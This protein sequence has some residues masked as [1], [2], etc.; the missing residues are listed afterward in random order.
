MI[1]ISD[2]IS[3][4]KIESEIFIFDRKTSTIHSLNR[5]ASYIW[6][7]LTENNDANEITEKVYNQF[8]IDR[9]TAEKDIS[10]FINE[11]TEKR[12]LQTGT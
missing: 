11:L 12:I 4:R 10:N 1:R 8:E 2:S 3:V 6:D 9:K 5:V 7:L